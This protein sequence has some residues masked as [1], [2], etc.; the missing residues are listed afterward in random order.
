MKYIGMPLAMWL[1]FGKS[2]E[3]NLTAVFGCGAAEAKGDDYCDCGYK[4]RN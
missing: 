2:F 1:F 3:K 4:K